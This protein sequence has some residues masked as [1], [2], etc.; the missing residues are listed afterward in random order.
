[1]KDVSRRTFL[2]GALASTLGT[3]V[4]GTAGALAE[5]A[6]T[7]EVVTVSSEGLSFD[8][9]YDIVVVGFGGAGACAA[10]EAHDAGARVLIVEKQAEATHFSNTR[11]SGGYFHFPDPTGDDKALV[12][13]VKAMMSGENCEW[14]LEGEQPHVSQEMAEMYAKGVRQV[15]D[16]LMA[17]SPD[18]DPSF[19]AP[20]GNASFPMFPCYEEAKYG[21][22]KSARYIGYKEADTSLRPQ[23]RPRL[24]KTMGEAFHWALIEDG[25]KTQRPGIDIMYETPAKEL[26]AKDGQVV[27]VVVESNGQLLRI[28]ANRAVILTSGGYEY[29]LPMR[30]AFL[31][32]PGVKGWCFYGSPDNTGDGIEMAMK[33][34]AGLAKVGKAASRIEVAV[35]YGKHYE[36]EGLKM[37][38]ASAITSAKNSMIVDNYGK[39]YADE[40]IITDSGRPFR[41]QFYKEALHYELQ[42]MSYPRVPSWIIFD[43]T[44]RTES[45][46]VSTSYS[47][48]AFGL[49]PWAKDNS[50]AIE[51]GWILKAD[52]LEELAEKIREDGENRDMITAEQLKASVEQFN[53]YCEAGEDKDFGR[54]PETMAPVVTPPFYAMKL[55]PG[56]PNTKG[57]IDANS[58]RQVIDWDGNPIPRLY[59][60]GEISSVFKFTYQAG[61]N[62]TECIV[63]GRQA[64][65]EAAK[66]TSWTGHDAPKS[67]KADVKL[68][69][70]V[71]TDEE[72]PTVNPADCKDGVY[73]ATAEGMNGNFDVTVTIKDGK[74]TQVDVG[75]NTETAGLGSVAIEQIPGRIVAAQSA[76]VDVYST[77]TITSKAIIK[78]VKLALVQAAK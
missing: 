50:D 60:A 42:T 78:A 65:I 31:E 52:T 34:G 64:G 57:G 71:I 16:F 6:G 40:F 44:R 73:T 25:V 24:T 77:A 55:Y 4:L 12:E 29:N 33:V 26:I 47:V 3:A 19:M 5:G 53:S 75:E 20:G 45:C 2:K 72:I 32:G 23:D 14:K 22:T 15:P 8:K 49:V 39:R 62:L 18:L 51:R 9:E 66:E 17:Q 74:I 11:L 67:D 76:D 54:S 30:R 70:T 36:E 43:E 69:K 7:T 28:C 56:G 27:G 46:A 1:M 59:T 63:C 41:Y 68:E 37:G 61:G 10:I 38:I 35:P 48:A 13:Y 21:G 58:K